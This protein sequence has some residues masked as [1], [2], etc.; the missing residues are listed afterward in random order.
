MH[1]THGLWKLWCDASDGAHRSRS[2]CFKWKS[3]CNYSLCTKHPLLTEKNLIFNDSWLK[4]KVFHALALGTFIIQRTRLNGFSSSTMWGDVIVLRKK[5]SFGQSALEPL[6]LHILPADY[7]LVSG[8][9]AVWRSET[10]S[11]LVTVSGKRH[12]ANQKGPSVRK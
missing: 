12:A 9:S 2:D 3:L 10:T 7:K 4:F 5:S 1:S 11:A 8:W 6:S